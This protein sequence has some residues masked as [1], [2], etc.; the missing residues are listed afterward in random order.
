VFFIVYDL[1]ADARG[2]IV[3]QYP[4]CISNIIVGEGSM[5]LS[6]KPSRDRLVINEI[7]NVTESMKVLFG[8]L[9]SVRIL[10][11]EAG[12]TLM[13]LAKLLQT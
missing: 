13:I 11:L 8:A 10:V 5:L 3:S 12:F 1:F 4:E 6:I 7:N 9:D 2:G